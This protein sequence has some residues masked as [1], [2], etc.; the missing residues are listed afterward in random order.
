MFCLPLD[1]SCNADVEP[2]LGYTVSDISRSL[3][4]K[5]NYRLQLSLV[6][7]DSGIIYLIGELSVGTATESASD[8]RRPD[9]GPGPDCP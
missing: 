2:M 6:F 7:P 3:Y 9:P 8:D 5:S 4:C 1:I